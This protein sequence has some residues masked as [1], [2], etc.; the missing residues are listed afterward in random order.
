MPDAPKGLCQVTLLHGSGT[1]GHVDELSRFVTSQI[2]ALHRGAVTA[3]EE[4]ARA[5]TGQD[6]AQQ[7]DHNRRIDLRQ[8][9]PT[10]SAASRNCLQY[11][12]AVST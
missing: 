9:V 3:T 4:T 10:F 1:S 2:L 5:R 7:Q 6:P 11:T 12:V 8:S